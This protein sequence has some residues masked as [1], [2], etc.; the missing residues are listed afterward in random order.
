MARRYTIIIERD[1]G[2]WLVSEVIGLPGCH[3]QA[4]T[5]DEL[6]KRTKEAIRAYVESSEEPEI[7]EEFVG[8]QQIEI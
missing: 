1:E 5:M 3:T 8:V 2:G 7:S 4:K 6:I